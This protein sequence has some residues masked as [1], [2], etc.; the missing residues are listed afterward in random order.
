MPAKEA[1][2][3]AKINHLLEDAGWRFFAEGGQAANICLEPTV[4]LKPI[5]LDA[6]GEDFEKHPKDFIDFLLLDAKG[7][8]L[9]VLEAKSESKDPLVGKEKARRYAASQTCRFVLLSN[10]NLH[11]IHGFQ[12]A[13]KHRRDR[14]LFSQ[15]PSRTAP[16]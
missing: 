7:F 12:A 11:A 16:R 9:I 14:F 5:D 8:L 10:G 4:K 1:T 15:C 2:A 6:L 13:V 3:R